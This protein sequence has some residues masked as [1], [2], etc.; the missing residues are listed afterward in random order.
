M[1]HPIDNLQCIRLPVPRGSTSAYLPTATGLDG[2]EVHRLLWYNPASPLATDSDGSPVLSAASAPLLEACLDLKGEGRD[3]PVRNLPLRLLD[4]ACRDTLV[5]LHRRLRWEASSVKLAGTHPGGTPVLLLYAA[6]GS[7]SRPAGPPRS[8]VQVQV[9]QGARRKLS[10]TSTPRATAGCAAW[11]A[12]PRGR[13]P[14]PRS[15]RST[16]AAGA[17]STTSPSPS[18]KA[19]TAPPHPRRA[20]PGRLQRGLEQLLHREHRL[21]RAPQ[22]LLRVTPRP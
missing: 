11:N 16:A 7:T 10:P 5:P 15:S 21:P 3:T 9:P 19:R 1:T 18:S 14:G 20:P 4:A 13:S 6:H 12:S 22:P 17:R 8:V 2:V